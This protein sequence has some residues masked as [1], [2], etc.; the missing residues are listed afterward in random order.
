MFG[1]FC[2]ELRE[3]LWEGAELC[4]FP[5]IDVLCGFIQPHDGA[6]KSFQFV[7]QVIPW[8][9]T[10]GRDKLLLRFAPGLQTARQGAFSLIRERQET[11]PHG[12]PIRYG[13]EPFFLQQTEAARQCRGVDDEH[14]GER[15]DGDGLVLGDADQ[16]CELRRTHSS[17]LQGR[18]IGTSHG[19]SGPAKA[20]RGTVA[21]SCKVQLAGVRHFL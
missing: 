5:G 11:L 17:F 15:A 13:D 18:V 9:S 12:G 14:A 4:R 3:Y 6:S 10:H 2:P 1:F 8:L 16:D 21:R 20:E 7:P 19:A